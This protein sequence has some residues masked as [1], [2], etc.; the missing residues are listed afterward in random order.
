MSRASWP[1]GPSAPDHMVSWSYGLM[2]IWS[3]GHMVS[4][5]Y[6]L[7]VIWSHGHGITG[8]PPHIPPE[9]LHRPRCFSC[10]EN[11]WGIPGESTARTTHDQGLTMGESDLEGQVPLILEKY[12]RTV[13][14]L[15][16]RPPQRHALGLYRS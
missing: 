2:V 1:M 5:S 13:P 4:W 11:Q 6:G 16:N 15:L 7:M 14:Q 12:C 8:L 10:S 3:H 9:P